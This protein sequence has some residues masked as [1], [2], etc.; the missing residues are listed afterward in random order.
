MKISVM[1]KK[2]ISQFR[3]A[4]FLFTETATEIE[5]SEEQKRQIEAEPMLMVAKS[6]PQVGPKNQ[7]KEK[8]K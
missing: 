6:A 5:V 7:N 8:A 1:T 3:R 4:G 2:G